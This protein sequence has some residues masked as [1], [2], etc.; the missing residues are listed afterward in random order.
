ML[1]DLIIMMDT[2]DYENNGC[3]HLISA[4][5]Q[6]DDIELHF[7]LST[8]E[9]CTPPQFWKINCQSVKEHKLFLGRIDHP[10][11]IY[12]DHI[13]LSN[14]NESPVELTFSGQ[15]QDVFSMIGKLYA[16]H[17]KIVG[18]YIPFHTYLNCS[19]D[20]VQLLNGR[21]GLLAEGPEKLINGY[22]EVL[23]AEGFT[24]SI[25]PTRK[26]YYINGQFVNF[27]GERQ[28]LLLMGSSYIVAADIK[29][30]KEEYQLDSKIEIIYQFVQHNLTNSHFEDWVYSEHDLEILLGKYL[31]ADVIAANYS[32]EASTSEVRQF[33]DEFLSTYFAA[34]LIYPIEG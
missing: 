28:Y 27:Q 29:L 15:S 26:P 34:I 4:I 23:D 10:F 1:D 8:G 14:H 17:V 7:R 30:Q 16:K 21:Y 32:D 12:M 3:I 20:I 9:D 19:L 6:E 22:Q 24:T 18:N 31:Y 11:E 2:V 13:L 25:L 5:E 33:L